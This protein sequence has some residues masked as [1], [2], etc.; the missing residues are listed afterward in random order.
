MD[1]ALRPRGLTASI[2]NLNTGLTN[3]ERDD[4]THDT[5]KG[6]KLETGDGDGRKLGLGQNGSL[7]KCEECDA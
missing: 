1:D 2:S 4:F 3:M 6:K 5:T 7:L